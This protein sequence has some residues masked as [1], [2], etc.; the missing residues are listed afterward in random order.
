MVLQAAH[1]L[2]D[3]AMS[4]VGDTLFPATVHYAT[5]NSPSS[6]FVRGSICML[7]GGFLFVKSGLALRLENCVLRLLGNRPTEPEP[8]M[9]SARTI[10]GLGGA[11]F[12]SYGLYCIASALTDL[13]M[14][15]FTDSTPTC[16]QPGDEKL[17]AELLGRLH[18]CT[19]AN[20]ILQEVKAGGVVGVKFEP[21]SNAYLD[22][23][24]RVIHLPR[25][26]SR[27]EQLATTVSHLCNVK[28]TIEP[29]KILE[30]E[31]KSGQ[32]GQKD[33]LEKMIKLSWR[34]NYCQHKISETCIQTQGWHTSTDLYA[35]KFKGPNPP[36]ETAEKMWQDYMND[37]AQ[38]EH[39]SR[40]YANWKSVRGS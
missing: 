33:F 35:D 18:N 20:D 23:H 4:L 8:R 15:A 30:R 3:S 24:A 5:H 31:I 25:F 37:P 36:W 34:A 38:G 10:V 16:P 40:V 32:L 7:G 14:S 27:D 6:K 22:T 29:A 9:T 11:A 12:I 17:L 26:A 28:H 2:Y 1:S 21:D 39:R 19:A 13:T